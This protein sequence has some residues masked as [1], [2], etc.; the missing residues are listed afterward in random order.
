MDAI[1]RIALVADAGW[2]VAIGGTIATA[3]L[4]ATSGEASHVTVEPVPGGAA[5]TASGR[6]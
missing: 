1:R 6:F 5:V 3:I 4:Y 2:V